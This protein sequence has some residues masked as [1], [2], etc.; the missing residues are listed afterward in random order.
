MT[1]TIN[2]SQLIINLEIGDDTDEIGAAW[3]ILTETG[4]FTTNKS[5]KLLVFNP[6]QF[7]LTKLNLPP[8][9]AVNGS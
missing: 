4:F 2:Y 9:S 7:G 6:F 3:V 8:S 5:L 1:K